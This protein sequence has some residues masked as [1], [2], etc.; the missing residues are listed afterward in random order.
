MYGCI[1]YY[2][3]KFNVFEYINYE[4]EDT[5]SVFFFMYFVNYT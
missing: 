2:Y 1:F 3:L 4:G 5:T